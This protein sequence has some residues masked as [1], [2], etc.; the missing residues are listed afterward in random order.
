MDNDFDLEILAP[1]DSD[2]PDVSVSA[3]DSAQSTSILN[4]P[5]DNPQTNPQPEMKFEYNVAIV[6]E[7]DAAKSTFIGCMTKEIC[8]DGRGKV[9]L[10]VLTLKHEK[11]TGRTSNINTVMARFGNTDIRFLDLAGHEKY[12]NITMQGLTRFKPDLAILLV[13]ANRDVT[14]MTREHFR[15]CYSLEIPIV[16]CISKIDIAP[17]KKYNETLANIKK[18]IKTKGT[19]QISA[20]TTDKIHPYPI[21]DDNTFARS[22]TAFGVNPFG[23]V[24][25]FNISNV[26]REGLDLVGKFLGSI[27]FERVDNGLSEFM[28]KTSTTKLFIVY[29]PY[30]VKGIGF[31]VFGVNKG[32][33]ISIGD[34]L[35]IGPISEIF[36][37]F[38]V[39][40]IRNAFDEDAES[41]EHGQSGCL[42]INFKRFKATKKL[43]R[44]TVVTDKPHMTAEILATVFIFSHHSTITRGYAPYLHC[45]NVATTACVKDIYAVDKEDDHDPQTRL[46]LLRTNDRGY[47]RF[48]MPL[49]QFIYPDLMILFRESGTKGVG[50]VISIAE[51]KPEKKKRGRVGDDKRGRR[52]P[53]RTVEKIID[54]PSPASNGVGVEVIQ[55]PPPMQPLK[56][57][58]VPPKQTPE[59]VKI[60]KYVKAPEHVKEPEPKQEI[61]T[62]APR[63]SGGSR[64]EKSVTF[65]KE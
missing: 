53:R 11:E 63:R 35:K 21:K 30:E 51:Y 1:D 15:V 43:L 56:P 55:K 9:R 16:V 6:G 57:T 23:F 54:G 25:I 5:I 65:K 48:T 36:H 33:R 13:A 29:K 32:S 4:Q 24:P 45:G 47:I 49:A 40:S 62:R 44:R 26:T 8:D 52:P 3:A 37:D 60:P 27:K 31:A 7:V 2:Y 17:P 12:L 61:K 42:G 59:H 38:T 46:E 10:D 34:R 64:G 19:D 58:Y 39:K 50:R 41:L 14:A 20:A 22:I 28:T 18:L